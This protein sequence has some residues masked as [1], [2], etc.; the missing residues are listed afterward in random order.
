MNWLQKVFVYGAL[1]TILVSGVSAQ[2]LR[3]NQPDVIGGGLVFTNQDRDS[4]PFLTEVGAG[5]G[6]EFFLR[7]NVNPKFFLSAATG[8]QSITDKMLTMD[9]FRTTLF[10]SVEVKAG[11]NLS[12]DNV[13]KP[14]VFAGLNA[15]GWKSTVKTP[16]GDFSSDRYYDAALVLGGGAEYALNDKVSLGFSGDYR[17]V[18]SAEGDAKPKFWVVKAGVSYAMSKA[19]KAYK[20]DEIEY[21]MDEKEIASLDDLFRETTTSKKSTKG[22]T[23]EEDAL[24]LLFQPDESGTAGLTENSESESLTP[25]EN[26]E[27]TEYPDTDVGRLMA[28]VQEMQTEMKQKNQ[29]IDDLQ[30][31]V[32][33]NEQSLSEL[34]GQSAGSVGD[35]EFKDQYASALNKFYARR[36]RE[37][38][39]QFEELIQSNPRHFLSSNCHYWIGESYNALGEFRKA[40]DEFSTVLGYRSSYKFAAALIMRG[41]CYLKLG[42]S[43]TAREQ[44]RQLINKYPDSEFAPKAMNYLGQL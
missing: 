30:Q 36:Y 17:Y 38:I 40:I 6:I 37:A 16:L 42:D 21:P 34:S 13:F 43:N 32:R 10:P 9:K 7:Y 12:P 4:N 8:I 29:I 31:Q 24:S 33:Q 23:S 27:A 39:P 28:K 18:F 25:S 44:F 41:I 35:S 14:M 5:P 1:L 19:V 11:L 15:F 22:G 3:L 26:S 20:G 2:S